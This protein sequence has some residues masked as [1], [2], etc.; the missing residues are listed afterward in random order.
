MQA[1]DLAA[2]AEPAAD[3]LERDADHPGY[4]AAR[5]AAYSQR[6]PALASA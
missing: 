4:P 3:L 6:D 2:A 1:L 5:E